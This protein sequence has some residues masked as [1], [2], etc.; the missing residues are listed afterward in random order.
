MKIL[1][2]MQVELKKLVPIV[3]S[4]VAVLGGLIFGGIFLFKRKSLKKETETIRGEQRQDDQKCSTL[5]TQYEAALIDPTVSKAELKVLLKEGFTQCPKEFEEIKKKST[6]DEKKDRVSDE[7]EGNNSDDPSIKASG[8][9]NIPEGDKGDAQSEHST[10]SPQVNINIIEPKGKFILNV[11]GEKET[12]KLNGAIRTLLESAKRANVKPEII[13]EIESFA[14]FQTKRNFDELR[15]SLTEPEFAEQMIQVAEAYDCRAV[16]SGMKS[17]SQLDV[18][19]TIICKFEKYKSLLSPET[20]RDLKLT[21]LVLL[22][23]KNNFLV[24]HAI[25]KELIDLQEPSEFDS[26][27]ALNAVLRMNQADPFYWIKKYSSLWADM[28][29]PFHSLLAASK[30]SHSFLKFSSPLYIELTDVKTHEEWCSILDEIVLREDKLK[31]LQT[32]SLFFSSAGVL[33]PQ[34]PYA[35][36]LS[37]ACEAQTK[38]VNEFKTNPIA[39]R[40]AEALV[41]SVNIASEG[42]QATS[43]LLFLLKP[44]GQYLIARDGVLGTKIGLQNWTL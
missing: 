13:G 19:C 21:S 26:I 18:K 42:I 9:N 12:E 37:K 29:A 30:S 39:L 16:S 33:R 41:K 22:D 3:V 20:I 32:I 38:R 27:R 34:S 14:N 10:E 5:L 15:K 7:L 17:S 6:S 11:P 4:V 40:M 23:E 36:A 31:N 35:I 25:L 44:F 28:P 2:R 8:T 1:F 43:E 24:E